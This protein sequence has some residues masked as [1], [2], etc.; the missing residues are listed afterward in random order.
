MPP[1]LAE[2]IETDGRGGYAL[3]TVC[4]RRTRRYHGLLV[5]A[6]QPPTGRMM[7]IQGYDAW[8]DWEGESLPL[9]QQLYAPYVVAP[10]NSRLLDDFTTRPW[11]TWTFRLPDGTLLRQ[12]LFMPRGRSTVVLRWGWQDG[13]RHRPLR[14]MLRPYLSGRDHHA[15][16]RENPGF[17]F[18][19]EIRP[20]RWTWRPYPGIPAIHA[21]ANARFHAES[22]W[23][24]QFL[25]ETERER[26]LEELEDVAAPGTFHWDLATGPAVLAWSADAAAFDADLDPVTLV[27]RW[28]DEEA[29]RREKLTSERRLAETYLV[30]GRARRTVI[31]GYPW[32]TDWGRDTFIALRGLCLATGDL[33]PAGEILEAWAGLVDQGMLPNRF[34]DAGEDPEFNSVDASLWFILVA[35]EYFT[36][37]QRQRLE[38]TPTRQKRLREA[39]RAILVGYA[40]GT[41][42]GIRLEE[43]GLLAAGQPGVQLTWMDA[44][45][46]DWV[47]TPRIGKPVEIQALWLNALAA[48]PDLLP[49]GPAWLVCGKRSFEERFWNV[50]TG[51]LYDVIDVDH[52]P[53]KLDGSVRPNQLFACGGLPLTLTTPART[54]SILRVVEE[55]LLTPLGPRSLSPAS[56]EYH[57]RYQGNVTARDGAYH[58]GTVWPW[59]LGAYL[60]AALKLHGATPEHR[61]K[62]RQQ[63]LDPLERHRREA[64]LE[65]LSEIA[66]GDA[67][68]TPRGCPFQAWSVG[69]YLRIKSL[70][71]D[72]DVA[73]SAP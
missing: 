42:Y 55:H 36:A 22:L 37:C 65:H 7:L 21:T 9:S 29:K 3:G 61:R 23:Y 40:A 53:G 32:F 15:I 33:E 34:P 49:A 26:G 5:A 8:L 41:R 70:L 13:S 56:T 20:Q 31:A 16:H 18:A 44:K 54:A 25:Y 47:V 48:F 52:V 4:G 11:P 45:V 28:A 39:V 51:A 60:E 6:T 27:T 67:P 66:D 50:E 64:G 17:E 71:R 19:P 59:L 68:H 38:I 43:D 62:L 1:P 35:R 12:E 73:E 46:G 57:G 2:W 10:D 24:R 58:Q 72:P 30:T 63:W 14:L 69:E